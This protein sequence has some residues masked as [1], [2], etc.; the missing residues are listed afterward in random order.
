MS[1]TAPKAWYSYPKKEAHGEIAK[2]VDGMRKRQAGY[3]D[4][5]IHCM[6]LRI[7]TQDLAGDGLTMGDSGRLRYNLAASTVDT[8]SLIHI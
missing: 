8:L 4:S 1:R 6:R 7:G 3:R 2:V 5:V